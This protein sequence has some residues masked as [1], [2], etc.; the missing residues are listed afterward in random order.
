M[1]FGKVFRIAAREFASTAFTKGFI[2]GA[3]VV[4]AVTFAAI[5]LIGF[6]VNRAKPPVEAGTLAVIDRSG[7]VA[8]LFAERIA[9]E[10]IAARRAE[11]AQDIQDA[12][13][14][15]SGAGPGGAGVGEALTDAVARTLGEVPDIRLDVLTDATADAET[16]MGRVREGLTQTVPR[17]DPSRPL[18]VLVFDAHAVRALP[19][20]ATDG[21]A[22][23]DAEG[24]TAAAAASGFGGYTLSVRPKLDDRTVGEIRQAA[25]WAI[26]EARYR[27]NGYDRAQLDDLTSVDAGETREI[28]AT[29]TRDAS[30]EWRILL[31]GAMM[32]LIL[33][34]V[35]TGGQYLL[36]TTI[37]EKS[38]RV[39]EL[40]LSAVSSMELMTGKILGQMAVGL[41]LTMVYSAVGIAALLTFALTDLVRPLDLVYMLVF[42]V[43]AYF[44]FGS[45]LAAIGAAVNELREA[46]SLMMP[47]MLL[48]MVPYF[49]FLPISRDPN[50]MYSVVLSYVPPINPLVMML[51]VAS[52]DPPATWEIL[53][54]ILVGVVGSVACVWLAAKV[55]RIGLLMF[56]KPPTF[57]TLVKWVR[58]A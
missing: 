12:A 35:F 51:R 23:S 16:V 29:G 28:T 10:A 34:G 8:E 39:V 15:I 30:F 3:L 41:M 7:E 38:S 48:T 5:P 54:S 6:L 50:A 58:M 43:L 33:M 56:G 9:R 11:V 20:T 57:G 45:L 19:A 4:P 47:V 36:T 40:L 2:I 27:A 55:F 18:G 52:S 31:P 37:E 14:E 26:L 46:Q 49:L 17:T 53:L 21:S 32:L 44:M 13:A 1:N 42:F 25:S 22:A 24:A